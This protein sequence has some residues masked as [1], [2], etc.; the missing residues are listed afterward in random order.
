MGRGAEQLGHDLM[1]TEIAS[2]LALAVIWFLACS[3]TM[4]TIAAILDWRDRRRDERG[5][6]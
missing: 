4:F 2:G 3:A 6:R 1:L 5:D